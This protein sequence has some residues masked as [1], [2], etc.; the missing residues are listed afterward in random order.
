MTELLAQLS[1]GQKQIIQDI[2]NLKAK[3]K[4]NEAVLD[5][6]CSQFNTLNHG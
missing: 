2:S 4:L 6:I 5:K 1:K 3:V